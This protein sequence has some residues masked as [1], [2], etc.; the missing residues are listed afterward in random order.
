MTDLLELV[1]KVKVDVLPQNLKFLL[2]AMTKSKFPDI[3]FSPTHPL[4]PNAPDTIGRALFGTP[5]FAGVFKQKILT[6][7]ESKIYIESR[8]ART[9]YAPGDIEK[10]KELL[11]KGLKELEKIE[12]VKIVEVRR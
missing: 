5:N 8:R 12:I 6:D 10:I 4:I 7:E 2:R 11:K 1:A 3:Y 9:I